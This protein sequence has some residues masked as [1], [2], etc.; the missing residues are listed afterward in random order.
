MRNNLLALKNI[1]PTRGGG[2]AAAPR[3]VSEPQTAGAGA[4]MR[5]IGLA[6]LML[7]SVGAARWMWRRRA[8]LATAGPEDEV[9]AAFELWGRPVGG[10]TLSELESRLRRRRQTAA[11][12]YLA[13]LRRHRYAPEPGET[14]S[15][16]G[17]RALR[18]AVSRGRG[19][20]VRA[21]TWMAIPPRLRRR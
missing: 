4:P 16:K 11:A 18:R 1:G 9:R 15:S 21:R 19:I 12:D 6:L 7:A 20:A 14:P 8:Q 3:P 5:A 17:R 2:T 10:A 13:G